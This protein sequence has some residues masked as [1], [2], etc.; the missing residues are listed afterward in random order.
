M[1][2]WWCGYL[3]AAIRLAVF[4]LGLLAAPLVVMA[5]P[6]DLNEPPGE[7]RRLVLCLD[8]TWNSVFDET[9]TPDG[10]I[11]LKPT[12]VLKLCR[13]VESSD[14]EGISQ[15]NYYLSGVGTVPRYP[16]PT[17]AMYSIV[18]KYLGGVWGAGF[19]ANVES[20]IEFLGMNYRS[21]DEV[22]VFGFSRGAATA[23]GLTQFLDWSGGLPSRN[24]TYYLPL[25]FRE[26]I[27]VRGQGNSDA[28]VAK[29]NAERS[30]EPSPKAPLEPFS[31]VSIRYLGVWDTVMA[32]GSRFESTGVKN[33]TVSRSF[34]V[35]DKPAKA[36][37]STRQALAIDEQRF[38]FRPEIWTHAREGQDMQQR[39]F[40]GVHSNVGGGYLHD[41]L[42]NGAFRWVLEGATNLGLELKKEFIRHYRPYPQDTL[43]ETYTTGAWL[44]DAV[45]F[46]LG[47]GVRQISGQP[48][49]ANLSVDRQ[50]VTRLL[51]DPSVTGRGGSL[52]FPRM[53][54]QP[55]RPANLLHFVAC[56]PQAPDALT[57]GG[58]SLDAVKQV[59]L[60]VTALKC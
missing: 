6:A 34:Y 11:V 15:L 20:A 47:D 33:A 42:A 60:L 8:G 40:A 22:Y 46:R 24:D 16:G 57:Q 35:D 50:V 43:Y 55:Y 36:V 7:F 38:D 37:R 12:N 2:R 53:N 27:R 17:N 58:A 4:A 21:G 28:W 13:A 45:R 31:P 26:F 10:F 18:D 59:L 32:L 9:R 23:R 44:I 30:A 5:A 41:G 14:A 54:G 49:S 48:G 39:W 25:L 29:I 52:R 19:E 51:T 1:F 3:V 56:D